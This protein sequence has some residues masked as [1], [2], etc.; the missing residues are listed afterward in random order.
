[1]ILNEVEDL[2]L[3]VVV[4]VDDFDSV[5]FEFTSWYSLEKLSLRIVSSLELKATVHYKWAQSTYRFQSSSHEC[6]CCLTWYYTFSWRT[7]SLSETRRSAR[8]LRSN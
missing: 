4:S 3:H 8:T 1:M 5:N 2:L 6:I 7:T